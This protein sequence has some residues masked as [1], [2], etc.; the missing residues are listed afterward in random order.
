MNEFKKKILF[1][2]NYKLCNKLII[3]NFI[4]N[5]NKNLINIY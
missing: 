1:Y 3:Y 5:L 4:I 2:I